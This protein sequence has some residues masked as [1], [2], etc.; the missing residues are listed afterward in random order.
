LKKLQA[1]VGVLILMA[2]FISPSNAS[3]E[4]EV[5]QKT[6]SHFSGSATALN[7]FQKS[8]IKSAVDSNPTAEKFIC[9][10][11]RF[12]SAPMSENIIVRA[13]AKAACDYAKLLNP[14]LSTYFQNKPSKS[15]SY[16]GK[17]LLTLKNAEI[18]YDGEIQS[19]AV[20]LGQC[21]LI[22]SNIPK[23]GFRGFPANGHIPHTGEV[24]IALV[25]ID[26]G[27][28]PGDPGIGERLA[29]H[30]DYLRDW[31]KTWSR[32]KM[33]YNV[34]IHEEWL[35][36]PKGADW[37][38]T[39][40]AKG[41]GVLKQYDQESL[42]QIIDV[43][44]PYFDFSGIDFVATIVPKEADSIHAFGI[45]GM[46]TVNTSEGVQEFFNY[47]GLG[48]YDGVREIGPLLV[49]EILHRQ[50]FLG[51]GP[52]NG[53][54]YGIMQNQW[55]KS[56]A[57]VS[58]E[59]F[60]SGWWDDSEYICIQSQTLSGI[61][62]GKLSSLD[63]PKTKLKSL[64]VRVNSE[65]AV[66]V[67][68]REDVDGDLTAYKLNVNKPNFF[69]GD[70]SNSDEKNWWQYLREPDGDIS[71]DRAVSYAGIQITNLGGGEFLIKSID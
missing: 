30:A 68:Y 14:A 54:P 13:R 17:V 63:A 3:N 1:I 49:H 8:Q 31:S 61:Y 62:K 53:S 20:D 71:I 29:K 7:T 24:R 38:Q 37:Y 26:F 16:S 43:A 66:V 55:G 40:S 19:L 42:R 36:A 70:D 45:Y 21:R 12:E 47:G 65:E 59:G 58:W 33:T 15:K 28:A 51:H 32:G 69:L 10:G 6:L 52:A 48:L 2:V 35:R 27:N 46:K 4:Y 9:T 34:Q 56:K 11:I 5:F 57:I 18:L 41:R 64:I 67:E 22:S 44:D 25:P 60:V 23:P 50:G 39:P